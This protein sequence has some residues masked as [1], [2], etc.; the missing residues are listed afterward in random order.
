MIFFQI[1]RR[2]VNTL[3]KVLNSPQPSTGIRFRGRA[4]PEEKSEE[5]VEKIE[6]KKETNL[7]DVISAQ[8]DF[9]RT[10]W[11]PSVAGNFQWKTQRFNL[12]ISR[13]VIIWKLF[14]I[15]FRFFLS[16]KFK[17]IS[18]LIFYWSA[19]GRSKIA[20]RNRNWLE[21]LKLMFKKSLPN[22]RKLSSE[23]Y[24]GKLSIILS[25]VVL[26]YEKSTCRRLPEWMT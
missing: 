21:R 2:A 9:K 25:L 6:R 7:W 15:F 4:R 1:L 8:Q 3:K 19:F 13:Q 20:I 26:L 16:A 18:R 11:A 12:P 22:Q 5:K 23:Y 10:Y 24:T 17:P 14:L